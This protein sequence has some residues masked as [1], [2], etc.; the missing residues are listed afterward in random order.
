[1][2][3]KI[4]LLLGPQTVYKHNP[5]ISNTLRENVAGHNPS[6]QSLSKEQDV[7]KN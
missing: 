4:K 1:M 7:Y 3:H 6:E 2:Q 5:L